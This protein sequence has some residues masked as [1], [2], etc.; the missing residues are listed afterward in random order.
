MDI[1]NGYQKKIKEDRIEKSV[2]SG[3]RR[4]YVGKGV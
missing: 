1:V 2:F 4:I 3:K